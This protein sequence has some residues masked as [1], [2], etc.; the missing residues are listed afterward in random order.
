MNG[1]AYPLAVAG[2]GTRIKKTI[3]GTIPVYVAQLMVT[4]ASA[5]V[6]TDE[7]ILG[8]VAVQTVSAV[9]LTFVRDVPASNVAESFL[10][11]LDANGVD[12]A[13]PEIE[14]FIELVNQA[15]A[16]ANGGS[17]SIVL[18]KNADGSE[19]LTLGNQ[20]GGGEFTGSANGAAGFGQKI[21]SIWL[22][23]PADD[24]LKS[25]KCELLQ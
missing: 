1:Q 24:G 5:V 7:G 22:G 10:D 19:T 14:A 25:L 2:S 4:D 6:K 17:L 12:T 15:G 18:V 9:R 20:K 16:A 13:Q 11:A 8:S 3:I 21:L 23:V